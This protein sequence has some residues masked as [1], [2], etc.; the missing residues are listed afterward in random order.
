MGKFNILFEL[1]KKLFN[2][3]AFA[4]KIQRLPYYLMQRN[5]ILRNR[6]LMSYKKND[7]CY[8]L[9]LGPSLKNVDFT[10]I[11][12]DIIALNSFFR[13][14]TS[15]DC[16]PT[17][18]CIIDDLDYTNSTYNE[19]SKAVEAFP[20]SIF[21]LNGKY[22]KEAEKIINN[23]VARYY[24]FMWKGYFNAKKKID[25]CKL[26]PAMGNVACFAI[27]SAFYIGYKEIIL[28]GC[29]FNSFTSRKEIHCYDESLNKKMSLAYELFCYS[30]C[31]D[32]H[33]QLNEYAKINNIKIC[34]ATNGSLIDAY[35]Y[36]ET[37]V[38][39]YLNKKG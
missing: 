31:A 39:Y 33:T 25:F 21:L 27:M 30:F 19:I 37:Q 9:G 28:L 36:D 18:Y 2:I 13:F 12:G 26:L 20:D 32:L 22:Y 11:N 10:K 7:V 6:E 38:Q 16:K 24:C 5:V 34:N 35:P 23:D 1:N 29:D 3:S 8:V 17:F 14:E 15:V 4:L